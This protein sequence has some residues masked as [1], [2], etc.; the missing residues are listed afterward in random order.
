[1]ELSELI[2]SVD[3][4]KY[5]EQYVELEEKNGEFWGLSPFQYEK[6]PSFS[7]R[8]EPPVF[9][10][11]SSGIGGNLYTFIKYYHKCSGKAAVEILKKAS[12]FRGDLDEPQKKLTAAVTCRKYA[13][14]TP[15]QKALPHTIL[16][17]TYMERYEIIPDKL[18][19]W[20]NEGISRESLQK[21][22]VRYDR[23]SDRLVYPIRNIS[24]Q[25]VNIGG[26]TLTADWKE[27]G[28][29]KYT[30]FYP[31]GQLDTIYGLAENMNSVRQQG[32]IILFEGC[33]SVLM[34]DSWGIHNCGAVLTSHLNPH[35]MKILASLGCHVVFALDKE[36]DIRKDYNINRLKRYV[37]VFYLCD[38]ENLLSEKDAPVDKGKEVFLKLY[39]Q[40]KHLL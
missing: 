20:E 12:D 33:K 22:Q 1:M 31:W 16:P 2:Q 13:V 21:F 23:F 29:R 15:E 10:D 35:Q 32:E 7:V 14:K 4:V 6:T 27:K 34:A 26:R 36:I 18:A 5:I 9:Y 8:R 11:Y 38:T 39:N 30:Y 37:N 19:V 3:I 25:I 40:K 24:G 17:D 28:V